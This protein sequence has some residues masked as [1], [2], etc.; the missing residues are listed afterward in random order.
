MKYFECRHCCV[1]KVLL[2]NLFDITISNKIPSSF[3]FARRC[4]RLVFRIFVLFNIFT[5]YKIL[6]YINQC[7]FVLSRGVCPIGNEQGEGQARVQH[8]VGV[9]AAAAHVDVRVPQRE[10][11]AQRAAAAV[12][13]PARVRP[14]AKG[15]RLIPSRHICAVS[16]YFK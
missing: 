8:A 5:Y 14:R 16:Q 2:I 7:A 3:Q 1:T 6:P 13:A 11:G 15:T 9:L 10:R 12:R 4:L